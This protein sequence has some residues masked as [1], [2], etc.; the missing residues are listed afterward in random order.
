[1][2]CNIYA[3][4]GDKVMV[5]K[6]SA[7]NGYDSDKEKVG[8]LLEI[9]KIY[10][11]NKA[12]AGQSSTTV[13][14]QEVPEAHFN[15][16]NLID[17]V[18]QPNDDD[19]ME[20]IEDENTL[21]TEAF[22]FAMRKWAID[23]KEQLEAMKMFAE[24]KVKLAES[25]MIVDYV[26]AFGKDC[27]GCLRHKKDIMLTYKIEGKETIYDLFLTYHQAN[28]L[29]EGLAKHLNVKELK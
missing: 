13:T 21:N 12:N 23:N 25:E 4:Y 24:G 17:Y 3:K 11:I 14:L 5:T 15:S 27:N 22:N 10:H 6:Q 20:I 16:V 2:S 8:N 19:Y 9:G 26:H 18:S 7:H 1:M 29:Y 28:S